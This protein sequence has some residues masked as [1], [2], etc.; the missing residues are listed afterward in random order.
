MI[1]V[2][3]PAEL[4]A[5]PQRLQLVRYERS[6]PH[7]KHVGTFAQIH[8]A[9]QAERAGFDDALFVSSEGHVLETTIANIGFVGED[10]VVWPAGPLL[11]GITWQLLDRS[12]PALGIPSTRRAVS[13]EEVAKFRAG[14]VCNSLGIATVEQLDG[15]KLAVDEMALAPVKRAFQE[16]AWDPL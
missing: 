16:L 7:I 3:P 12:L 9:E 1:T 6:L 15:L 13:L 4:E 14:F 5:T 8:F 10:S 2:R 11:P